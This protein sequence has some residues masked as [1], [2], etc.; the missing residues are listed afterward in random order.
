MPAFATHEIFGE[1]GIEG[2]L[3]SELG[4]AVSRHRTVF[5]VGCQGPDIFF[6]NPFL[7]GGRKEVNLGS[8]M[9]ETRINCFFQRYLEELLQIRDRSELEIGISY[10]LGFLSH[11]SLD[12]ELHPYIYSRI[13]YVAD[14]EAS[15]GTTLPLH[16]RM[17]AV[18][19]MHML[20]MKK[21]CMPSAYYPEKRIKISKQELAVV[22]GILSRTLQ[23]VYHV[24]VKPRHVRE[25]YRWMRVVM[26]CVYDHS[27]QKGGEKTCCDK[28][29]VRYLPVIRNMTVGD[30]LK[31]DMDVMNR[32][33]V[34]WRN[35]WERDKPC[36]E[37]VWEL[38]DNAQERYQGYLQHIEP[39]L[40]GMI[41]RML[42]LE[43]RQSRAEYVREALA[44]QIPETVKALENRNYHSGMED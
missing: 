26:K 32:K 11:Y 16:H 23:K 41:K 25:S 36:S 44:A 24:L 42:L 17:E 8:R 2:V 27:G 6:Y 9:H 13:G 22:A 30:Y 34:L 38:Y 10:F 39:V 43:K 31:D 12:A 33:T 14:G 37:S 15:S 5:Y 28:S 40:M 20:M 35:P 29:P 19:D 3:T 7:S 18:M 4:K 21:E 1:D